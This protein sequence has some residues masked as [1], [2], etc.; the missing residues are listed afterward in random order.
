VS[1]LA[2]DF[3][4]ARVLHARM[5][6]FTRHP[7]AALGAYRELALADPGDTRAACNCAKF[8]FLLGRY[9]ELDALLRDQ[10]DHARYSDELDQIN[11]LLTRARNGPGWRSPIEFKT[12]HYVITSDIDRKTCVE[13]G[14]VL[15]NSLG[16]YIARMRPLPKDKPEPFRVY[17]FGGFAGYSRYVQDALSARAENTA[18]LYDPRLKQL[19]I[20]N[21]PDHQ[22]MLQTV[23][24]E[25]L[26]Q[27][28][29]RWLDDP[30]RWLNE[31]LAEYYENADFTLGPSN[32]IRIHPEHLRVIRAHD[33]KL[34]P[35]SAFIK[36]DP[37][38]FYAAAELDYAEAWALVHFLLNSTP[39]HRKIFD[40]LL[41][42]LQRGDENDDALEH[43]FLGADFAKLQTEFDAYVAAMQ[44]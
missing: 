40:A 1:A 14:E 15:E 18:G 11:S 21:L 24:H 19:L 30:P 28:V 29:D 35:L 16:R 2:P 37:A 44:N 9:A 27:Y 5:L 32:E 17:L 22:Q 43:A 34:I 39:A 20:W 36:Y 23:R 10:V 8:E 38:H 12:E 3:H 31:G 13:A 25:G 26:H 33:D 4:P 41:D 7:E 6:E 42:A